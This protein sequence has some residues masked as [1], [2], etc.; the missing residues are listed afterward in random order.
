LFLSPVD[1]EPELD[2]VYNY[3]VLLK[4][5]FMAAHFLVSRSGAYLKNIKQTLAL[6]KI[7]RLL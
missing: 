1:E 3:G 4:L 6:Q 5:F 7:R 2:I